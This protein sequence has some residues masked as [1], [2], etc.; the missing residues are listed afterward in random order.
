MY[1]SVDDDKERALATLKPFISDYYGERIDI[2]EHGVFGPMDEV[3]ERLRAFADAGVT[4]FILGVPTLDITHIEKI[5][6]DV[7]PQLQS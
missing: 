7:V 5:V 3:I 1:V 2:T 6:K 4:M